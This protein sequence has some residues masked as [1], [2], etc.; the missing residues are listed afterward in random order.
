MCECLDTLR[1]DGE[2]VDITIHGKHIVARGGLVVMAVIERNGHIA[3]E[4][5]IDTS[6]GHLQLIAKTLLVEY[7]ELEG[8]DEHSAAF[9]LASMELSSERQDKSHELYA[10]APNDSLPEEP[11]MPIN[12]QRA[13]RQLMSGAKEN[14]S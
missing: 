9:E 10:D 2:A 8:V 14:M 5:M 4:A 13:L 3:L 7:A 1:P 6:P 12:L 11:T